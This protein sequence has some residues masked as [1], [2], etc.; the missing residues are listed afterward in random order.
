M[1]TLKMVWNERKSKDENGE[2]A[3]N[4]LWKNEEEYLISG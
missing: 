3:A 2:V 1:Y 4:F